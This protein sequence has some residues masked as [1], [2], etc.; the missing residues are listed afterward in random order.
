MFTFETFARIW[1]PA[2]VFVAVI[3]VLAIS[4]DIIGLEAAGIL[5]GGGAAVVLVN[6]IQRVGFAGDV[7]RDREHE[8]RE[9]YSRY[10]MWPG[11]APDDLIAQARREGLLEH[12]TVKRDDGRTV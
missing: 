3:A 8:T 2:T 9:F 4:P 1:I 10:G 7:E 11:Q 12:V 6:Y 5:F